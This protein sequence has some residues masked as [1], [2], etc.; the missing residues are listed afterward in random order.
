[1]N[2]TKFQELFEKMSKAVEENN[3][4]MIKE[5]LGQIK[6]FI[7][8]SENLALAHGLIQNQDNP[9]IKEEIL[10]RIHA[11]VEKI[12]QLK[13][14]LPKEKVD[15]VIGV[16]PAKEPTPPKATTVSNGGGN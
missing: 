13:K 14:E 12:K 1:M 8:D 4:G 3:P 15:E 2:F 9:E 7:S 16:M 5:L 6:L 10:N 11:N